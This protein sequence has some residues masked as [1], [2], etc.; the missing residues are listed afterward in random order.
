MLSLLIALALGT[1][2]HAVSPVAA[3][4]GNDARRLIVLR[5]GE[6]TCGGIREAATYRELPIPEAR[7]VFSHEPPHP[8]TLAFSID[9][10]GRPTDIHE[11]SEAQPNG[12]NTS[13]AAPSLAAWQ[14]APGAVRTRCI[15]T[16]SVDALPAAEVPPADAYRAF[17]LRR[18]NPRLLHPFY[19]RTIPAGSDCF[20]PFPMFRLRAFPPYD[21]LDQRP[22]TIAWAMVG[23]DI[24]ARGRTRD[25][26]L[27]GGDGDAALGRASVKAVR[28]SRFA[29]AARHGCALPYARYPQMPLTP[30]PA[31]PTADYRPPDAQCEGVPGDWASMPP[32]TF[33]QP[34]R[35]RSIEGWAILRFDV[36]PWG[37][38]GNVEVVAAQ[39]ADAFGTA[40][41]A[42]VRRAKKAPSP[43]GFS[44]CVDKVV[45]KMRPRGAAA[46]PPPHEVIVR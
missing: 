11:I 35:R 8:L 5:P 28:R 42:I 17:A 20:D 4:D 33:P 39:P 7:Y 3:G 32:L 19:R 34:F 30:P 41:Q 15:V 46:D 43:R 14:F 12:V 21:E 16:Y 23:F 1:A 25:V 9:S 6:A 31:A 2:Q 29:P 22:G 40:A 10:A 24:D 13:D 45:F 36:A 18:G 44:G 37:E 38:T 27:L 26:R